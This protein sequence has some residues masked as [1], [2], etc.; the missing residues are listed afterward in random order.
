[1]TTMMTIDD[2]TVFFGAPLGDRHDEFVRNAAQKR[3]TKET[4]NQSGDDMQHW[5]ANFVVQL[6]GGV[7]CSG[8][9]IVEGG[10][11]K[12]IYVAGIGK[13]GEMSEQAEFNRFF[14]RPPTPDFIVQES[15]SKLRRIVV[16]D[17]VT[18]IV[19]T[20]RDA[21]VAAD[22]KYLDDASCDIVITDEDGTEVSYRKWYGKGYDP[23]ISRW[24]SSSVIDRSKR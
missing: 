20:L 22:E 18:T 11:A 13:T 9:A 12:A 16:G 2:R 10:A 4:L 8:T 14:Q 5:S 7:E 3:Y 19:G 17:E 21:E 15:K 24:E 6:S 23:E 1:M